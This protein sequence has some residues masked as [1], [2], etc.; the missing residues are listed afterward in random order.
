[1]GLLDS[2]TSMVGGAGGDQSKVAGGM[3]D[4]VQQHPGGIGG[5]LQSF[6]QNGQGGAVQQWAGGNTEGASPDQV[7]QGL[8][9]TGLID[10]VAQRTGMSPTMVKGAMAVMLPMV[11]H[12]FVSSGH[13]TSEGQMTGV[14]APETGGLLQSMLGRL[15]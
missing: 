3:M 7:E 8:G 10:S 11:I 4:A 5:I 6:Q 13:V 14:P 2:I 12:H 15:V 1:M 9:G